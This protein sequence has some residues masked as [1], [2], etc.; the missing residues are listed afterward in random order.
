[1][2]KIEEIPNESIVFRRFS[3]DQYYNGKPTTAVFE[4]RPIDRGK[5]SVNWHKYSSPEDTIEGAVK[6]NRSAKN[7]GCLSLEVKPIR[8][9]ELTVEHKPSRKN[10]A[11]SSIHSN[12]LVEA[13]DI[14]CNLSEVQ[15][16]ILASVIAKVEIPPS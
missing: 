9:I 1:L 10:R 4:P 15:R 12:Q 11:H 2:H 13:P 5:L 16:I 8:D 6:R 3:L 14:Y 7:C